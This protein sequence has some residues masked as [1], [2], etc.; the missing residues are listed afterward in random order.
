VKVICSRHKNYKP[1]P[2]LE[3]AEVVLSQEEKPSRRLDTQH[4]GAT[5][6]ISVTPSVN[7]LCQYPSHLGS[8]GVGIYPRKPRRCPS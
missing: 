4:E 7:T 8:N 2:L 3:I 1:E 6:A 5:R